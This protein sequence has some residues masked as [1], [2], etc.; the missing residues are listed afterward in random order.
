MSA[1]IQEI[2]SALKYIDSLEL[3]EPEVFANANNNLA[4][5][6]KFY[7]V[8]GLTPS[9]EYGVWVID[10]NDGAELNNIS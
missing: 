2:I 5:R 8:N 1:T 9:F 4:V 10:L 3:I 6:Y 7:N